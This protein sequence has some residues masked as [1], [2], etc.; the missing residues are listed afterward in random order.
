MVMARGLHHVTHSVH[1]LDALA[2]VYEGLGFTVSAANRHSWG[3][4]NR[5]V[6]LH[7][8]YV[9]LLA[10]AEPEK[11]VPHAP[12]SFSFGGFNRDFLERHE[13][14]AMVALESRDAEADGDDF[15]RA[16]IGDFAVFDFER[17]GRRPDGSTTK[18]GFSLTFAADPQA[19]D[20]GFFT[21]QEHYPENFWNPA[22]QLHG[23]TAKA[24][25]AVIM[26]AEEPADH[27]AFLSAFVGEGGVQATSTG[28]T[29]ATTRGV[30]QVMTPAAFHAHFAVTSPDLA[31]GPRLAALRFTVEDFA[32]AM[33][34]LKVGG[35]D[36]QVR[37]GRII[38]G[39]D[40]GMGATLVFE[41]AG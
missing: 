18:V 17:E 15:C 22:F 10:V 41:P 40:S 19:P 23:N 31:R 5:I 28:I 7:G 36:A 25:A 14:L 8:F 11:I 39:P 33:N 2:G 1:D 21:C 12:R 4:H 13:G 20:I 30:I 6:Q 35:I 24:I 26:V 27:Q 3:T 29:V 38:V 34:A 9:E 37:M 16:S 32:S